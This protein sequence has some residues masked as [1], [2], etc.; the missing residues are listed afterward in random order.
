MIYLL[1]AAVHYFSLGKV[2]K[3][4][5]K[6]MPCCSV[7][8]LVAIAVNMSDGFVESETWICKCGVILRSEA[9]SFLIDC[10]LDCSRR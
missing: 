6:L 10:I 5:L 2:L 3:L 4:E 7:C 9:A 1:L 8:T